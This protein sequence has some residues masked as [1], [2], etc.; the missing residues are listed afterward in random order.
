MQ[1]VRGQIN[2]VINLFN[3]MN[4]NTIEAYNYYKKLYPRSILFFHVKNK[5]ISL[6][7]DAE[8]ISKIVGVSINNNTFAFPDTNIEIL[9]ILGTR[10]VQIKIIDYRNAIGKLDIPDISV[11]KNDKINDY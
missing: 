11:L 6:F 3:T 10:G 5:Y 2:K 9:S 1:W 7:Q 8:E 4:R